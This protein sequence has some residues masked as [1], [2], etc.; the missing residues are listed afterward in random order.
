[1]FWET[2]G[3]TCNEFMEVNG[4]HSE[5]NLNTTLVLSHQV[6]TN[7]SPLKVG[8]SVPSHT[9]RHVHSFLVGRKSIIKYIY[10]YKLHVISEKSSVSQGILFLLQS[11]LPSEVF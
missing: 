11:N 2:V 8:K 7:V 4:G 1:M 3:T 10:I 5:A 6:S 9:F